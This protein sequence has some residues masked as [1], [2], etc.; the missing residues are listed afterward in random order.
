MS[1]SLLPGSL[2]AEIQ[3][4]VGTMAVEGFSFNETKDTLRM[5]VTMSRMSQST[6]EP[7]APQTASIYGFLADEYAA[8]LAE[9]DKEVLN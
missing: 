3:G 5:S 2:K 6:L 8:V 4:L 1:I 7:T 9:L